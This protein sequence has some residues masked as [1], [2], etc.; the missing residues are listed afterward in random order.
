MR[1]LVTGGAGFIGSHFVDALMDRQNLDA[2]KVSVLDKLTY[3]GKKS[4]L[5]KH[6][7]DSR[8]E[9]IVGDIGNR[10]LIQSLRG[11][12]DWIINFAAESHVDRSITNSTEF[13]NSNYSGVD[14]LLRS[15]IDTPT[16]FLQISTDEVYGSL[17]TGCANE[18]SELKP[19]SVYSAT[20][21]GADLLVLSYHNTFGLD[22]RI[23]RT[24]NNFGPRQF[25]E[26]L[27]PVA[28]INA[29]VG[30]P[31]P[32]YGNGTN[33]REWIPAHTNAQYLIRVILSGNSGEIYNIGSGIELTNLEIVNQIICLAN[34]NSK[35]EYVKD[36]LGHDLRYSVDASKVHRLITGPILFNLQSEIEE[37]IEYYRN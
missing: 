11:K 31:I 33:I 12:F 28:I 27:I 34:S 23:T 30:R 29:L 7:A 6:F 4:N 14:C 35:I 17:P 10:D 19:G 13:I 36:R 22:V 5:A 21:A 8:F 9:F 1:F 2:S 24:C 20:K 25:P 16:K 32:V 26:K 3:A 15:L 18:E 37:T